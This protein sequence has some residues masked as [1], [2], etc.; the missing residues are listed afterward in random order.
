MPHT[1]R[2]H[3][4]I[5]AKPEKVYRAFLEPDA[6]VR[7]LPPYGFTATIDQFSPTVGGGYKM[8]FKNYTTGGIHSF[9][10]SYID[11]QPHQ[12]IVYT[13]TF[14]DP[15]LL[16]DM[17][18]TVEIASASVGSDLQIVQEGIPTVIPLEACYLDWQQSLEQLVKLVEP[19]I[20]D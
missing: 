16:G 11:L 6:L 7:W 5:A 1:V 10:C 3:R 15:N 8:A 20:P 17:L 12:K 13:D 14:D 9:R 18:I 19:N 2:L 4:V